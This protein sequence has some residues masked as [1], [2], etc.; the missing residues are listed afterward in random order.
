V[1]REELKALACRLGVQLVEFQGISDLQLAELYGRARATVLAATLEPFGLVALE[2]LACGTPV[3]AVA[4]GGYRETVVNGVT[5]YLVGRSTLDM[6]DGIGR[7][8]DGALE[9]T[10]STLRELVVSKW[11]WD[12]AADR[13]M[14]ILR[15]TAG[16]ETG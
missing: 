13:Q 3:V 14:T 9:Q 16:I 10:R 15:A 2:S 5:G 12:E 8:L 4:E 11:S 7:V 1:Y 6:A